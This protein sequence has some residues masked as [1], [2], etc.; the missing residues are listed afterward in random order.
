MFDCSIIIETK[1]QI[2][3]FHLNIWSIYMD[4]F[5]YVCALVFV[6]KRFDLNLTLCL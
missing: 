3:E 2:I 6:M 1:T 5:V 4:I